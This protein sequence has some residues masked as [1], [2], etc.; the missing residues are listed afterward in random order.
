MNLIEAEKGQKT[1][2]KIGQTQKLKQNKEVENINHCQKKIMEKLFKKSAI[3]ININ[4]CI[5]T[6]K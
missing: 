4:T 6:L 1:F 3:I 5:L 2:T